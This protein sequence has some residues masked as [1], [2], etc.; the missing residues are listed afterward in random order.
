MLSPLQASS[1]LIITLAVLESTVSASFYKFRKWGLEDWW[2]AHLHWP[3][4]ES[5]AESDWSPITASQSSSSSS[6]GCGRKSNLIIA[7]IDAQQ[8]NNAGHTVSAQW[9][10]ID[11]NYFFKNG[12]VQ[13]TKVPN[14]DQWGILCP[15]ELPELLQQDLG[16]GLWL[17]LPQ[18]ELIS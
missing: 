15:Q 14:K 16:S 17:W 3:V 6:G 10:Y 4:T 5:K 13:Y 11:W 1:H 12:C 8:F 2:Q 7:R 9:N 18:K